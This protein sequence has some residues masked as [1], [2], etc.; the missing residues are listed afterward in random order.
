M[1]SFFKIPKGV[2]E[3]LDYYR[4]RFFWQ[5]D[6]HKK[7]YRLARWSILRKPKSVGGLGII[8]LEVQNKCLLRK[9]LLKLLNE[10]G[11]WQEILKKKYLKKKN[12]ITSK[13]EGGSQFWSGLM[14]VKNHF[15]ERGRFMVQDGTQTRF[16]ERSFPSLYNIARKKNVTV[17][18]VLSMMPFNISFRWAVVGENWI[19]WLEL[20]WCLLDKRLTRH[21]DT[22]VWNGC[23]TFSVRAM[24]ND[25]MT[26]EGVPFDTSWKVKVPLKIK[27]FLWYL[28]KGVVSLNIIWLRGI[29][30][31]ALN[32][33]FVV[34]TRQF[35]TF[36]I[37]RLLC[38][39]WAWLV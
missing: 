25:I 4:S 13:K 11:L 29:G 9:W 15:F 12:A 5:C 38:K 17:P 16:W 10:D 26:R 34:N 33:V 22:F 21:K 39:F 32:V 3:K 37:A 14:E 23:K 6:E 30:K 1:I 8:D 28:R 27:I 18:Q 7:K 24:Y 19:K 20:V 31:E 35:N 2:L 36:F